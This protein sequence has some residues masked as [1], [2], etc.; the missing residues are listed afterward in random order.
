MKEGLYTG[1]REKDYKSKKEMKIKNLNNPE[2]LTPLP[3]AKDFQYWSERMQNRQKE[4]QEGTL[5][6]NK[7]EVRLPETSSICFMSDLHVG[8]SDV[9]YKRIEQEVLS[10][11]QTPNA[12]AVVLG[13]AVDGFFFNPAQ[14]EAIEQVPEQYQY[15]KTMFQAL[16]KEKKVLAGLSGDH[17][18]WAKKMGVSAYSEFSQQTGGA[19]LEGVAYLTIKIGDFDYKI[20]MAHRLPGASIYNK[21]HPQMRLAKFGSGFGSDI[22]VS[23]HNHQK[24]LA[25]STQTGF[26]GET[27]KIHYIALGAYKSTDDYAKKLGFSEQQPEEMFGVSVHLNKDL[28]DIRVFDSIIR[29]NSELYKNGRES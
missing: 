13:D 15:I 23:G 22:I 28:K 18:G 3:S 10:I 29:G 1:A 6:T 11:L 7:V 24:Q 27:N 5:E 14:M 20:T 26:G 4:Y 16:G 9:N 19:L 17:D 2:F 12:Y 8:G 21:N 25:Q